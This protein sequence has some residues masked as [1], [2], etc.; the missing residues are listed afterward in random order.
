[1]IT[2]DGKFGS[3]LKVH[4]AVTAGIHIYILS[5]THS[6]VWHD[7]KY[8]LCE[9][10][11]GTTVGDLVLKVHAAVTAG[12]YTFICEVTNSH[13]WHDSTY[14]YIYCKYTWFK[15]GR[16]FFFSC[17]RDCEYI[18]LY[19]KWPIHMCDMFQYICICTYKWV[20]SGSDLKVHGVVTADTHAY[21]IWTR[22]H[23]HIHAHMCTHAH[24]HAHTHTHTH[25]FTLIHICIYF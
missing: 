7:P 13:V 6:H 10:T 17:W 20:K 12:I 1:M 4:A 22:K 2:H 11:H 5:V 19:V 21:M 15:V 14:I 25:V 8:L 16:I 23:A 18:H 3:I 24:T 9:Y